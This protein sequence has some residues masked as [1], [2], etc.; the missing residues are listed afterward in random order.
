M[1]LVYLYLSWLPTFQLCPNPSEGDP[2]RRLA[3]RKGLR[4]FA[5][6]DQA[7]KN[8]LMKKA[9]LKKERNYANGNTRFP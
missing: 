6:Y 9:L 5:A 1:L 3:I 8:R 2:E 7:E 4:W